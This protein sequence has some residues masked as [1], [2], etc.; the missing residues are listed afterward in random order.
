[1]VRL[2]GRERAQLLVQSDARA[3]L[4][5]FLGAWCARFTDG[6]PRRARWSLDVDPIEF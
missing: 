3:E 5:A 4:Q 6:P 2:A 1:M